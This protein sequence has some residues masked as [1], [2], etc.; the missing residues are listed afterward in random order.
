M[1]P[2]EVEIAFPSHA[3][4]KD[5]AVVGKPDSK[6]GEQVVAAVVC[7]NNAAIEECDLLAWAKDR[8]AGFKRPRQITFLTDSQMPRNATGKILHR[9]LREM[10]TE[11]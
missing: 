5:V 2:S 3:A 9:E 10:F 6:W 11:K 7:H 1:Y 4:V 8:L